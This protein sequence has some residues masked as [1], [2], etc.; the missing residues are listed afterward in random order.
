MFLLFRFF[1]TFAVVLFIGHY[2]P[3]FEIQNTTDAFFFALVLS[4]VN[5]VIRPVLILL[6]LPVTIL[7]LGL[8]TLVINFFTFFL[9][10]E[11]SYGVYFHSFSALFWG[12]FSIW[13]TGLITNRF[14][15]RVNIY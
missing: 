12:A 7:T 9:A 5:A 4:A 15:W 13:I 8:F 2:I 10:S 11:L 3:G 6:T 14:I 1:I